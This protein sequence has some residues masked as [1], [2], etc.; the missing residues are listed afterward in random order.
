MDKRNT[1]AWWPAP[2]ARTADSSRKRTPGARW[3]WRRPSILAE[4]YEEDEMGR[5]RLVQTLL[6]L[7]ALGLG[8]SETAQNDPGCIPMQPF[9]DATQGISGL[10]VTSGHLSENALLIQQAI[11]MTW[12][13]I[14]ADYR[15]TTGNAELPESVGTY[16]G[17]HVEFSVYDV[18]TKLEGAGPYFYR[19]HT[20]LG[21]VDGAY[22]Q[23]LMV[24]RPSDM[25]KN[26]IRYLTAFE[27]AMYAFE[28]IP[29]EGG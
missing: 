8:C 27:S 17:R 9:T 21:E 5:S 16:K 24:A 14:L 28:P 6:L 23:V 19:V 7:A 22:Y 11:P 26:R 2:T 18:E 10:V 12:E 13:E 25:A 29:R 1:M 3:A 4:Q 20:G 15:Q